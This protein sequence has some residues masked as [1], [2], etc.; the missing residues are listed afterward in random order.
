MLDVRANTEVIVPVGPFVDVTDGFTPETGVLL[1]TADEAELLKH[2]STTVVD[3]SG[4]TWAAI[5]TMDGHYGLTLTTSLTDTEG[6]LNVVVQDD[7]VCLP[8]KAV[9]RVLSEAAY[10]SMY[11]AKDA[12]FMDV[13][14]KTVGRADTQETE[15]DNLESA[16]SNYSATRG[17][18]GT[19]VPAAAADAANGLPI[20][21]AGD[22]DLDSRIQTDIAAILVDTGTTL[23]GKLNTAQADLDILTDSDGVILGAAGVDLVWDEVLTGAAHNVV[24][25]SGR[26]IRQLQERG[27]YQDGAIWIDTVNGTAGTDD[28]ENGTNFKP[29]DTLADALTLATSVGLSRFRITPGSSLT[30]ASTLTNKQF[31]GSG[32]TLA[33]G[34]QEITGTLIVGAEVSGTAL[35]ATGHAD[36]GLC[37]MGICTL[38]AFELVDCG[39]EDKL[40]LS[41]AADYHFNQCYHHAAS[42]TSVIIDMGAAVLNTVVHMHHHSGP[43]EIENLGQAGTDTVIFE[44]FGALTLNA[45]CIGGTVNIRGNI[46]LTNNGSGMTINDDARIDT[47]Q[48]NTECDTAISDAALAT[49]A[50]LATVD[51]VVDAIKAKTDNLPEGIVKNA[52]FSNFEFLMVL[53]S[54]HVTPATGLTVTGERSIDGG[55]FAGVSGTIAEV[56]NGIYQ[57]D[58]L[59]ADTNGDVITYRFSSGT[60]DDTFVTIK[61][62]A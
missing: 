55:A 31:F 38:G 14:I 62:T 48:V 9:F 10:D 61:T 30:F 39:L 7:S 23:D 5:T 24:N 57:I 25:S 51:T 26:R 22:L 40:T 33:L 3:I 52:T 12:G 1:S 15:A 46:T 41:A 21:D 18:T 20:S 34:G 16:C 60:A 11:A 53:T 43:V 56:S 13:N 28:F 44:G 6:Q 58:F 36:F 2:G 27:I 49:A 4:A 45:N 29:V 32:W 17:L 35:M 42:G 50:N 59:A 8:V 47:G 54:D 19:A 37:D